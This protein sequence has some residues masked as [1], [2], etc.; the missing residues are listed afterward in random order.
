MDKEPATVEALATKIETFG[1]GHTLAPHAAQ[2][3]TLAQAVRDALTAL[4]DA[5]RAA[6]NADA[7]EEIAQGTLR[8]QY[9]QNYLTARQTIGRTIAE[10]LFPKANRANPTPTPVPDTPPAP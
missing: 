7:E 1:P 2:L 8:R 4:D 9:E 5:V 6:K 10:R 3:K